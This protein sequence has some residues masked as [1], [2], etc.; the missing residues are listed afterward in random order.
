MCHNVSSEETPSSR[1]SGAADQ[2]AI[3]AQRIA[4]LKI[5]NEWCSSNICLK[6]SLKC[7]SSVSSQFCF[8]RTGKCNME[9]VMETCF[10]SAGLFALTGEN[11]QESLRCN[12]VVNIPFLLKS[13][14]AVAPE[15]DVAHMSASTNELIWPS[16]G[17]GESPVLLEFVVKPACQ[18]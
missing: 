14:K 1:R 11:K 10:S 6:S 2:S 5:V 9:S 8:F 3:T 18:T 12:A 13:L 4:M 16:G 15:A 7:M 17:C